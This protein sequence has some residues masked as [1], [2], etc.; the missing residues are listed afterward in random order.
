MQSTPD[1]ALPAPIVKSDSPS[2][3][4]ELQR[5]ERA[6]DEAENAVAGLPVPA[7]KSI[8][9]GLT[10]E[11]TELLDELIVTANP[12]SVSTVS[13]LAYV[14]CSIM[15]GLQAVSERAD[16]VL[17]RKNGVTFGWDRR[18][19]EERAVRSGKRQKCITVS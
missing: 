17:C 3:M 12:R 16:I 9:A 15:P 8:P 2:E 7:V 10:N 19:E 13:R 6:L 18:A 11:L 4:D 1:P 14:L 5:I